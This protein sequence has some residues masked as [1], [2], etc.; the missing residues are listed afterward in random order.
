M[1]NKVNVQMDKKSTILICV[2]I[3]SLLFV[4]FFVSLTRFSDNVPNE[5]VI[6][7]E[8]SYVSDHI[9]D[10]SVENTSIPTPSVNKYDYYDSINY[11]KV[12]VSN[13]NVKNGSLVLVD[14][15]VGCS[16]SDDELVPIHSSRTGK[17][18][19]KD[20]SLRLK[21]EAIKNID[22]FIMSFY[23]KY[24]NN[25]LGIAEG[26]KTAVSGAETDLST[27]Y[28]VK[29]TTYKTSNTLSDEDFGY[30]KEQSF[31]YG[32]IQRF[33][34]GKKDSTGF[35]ENLSIYRYVGLVHSC[36]MNHYNLSLEEYIDKIKT[37]K[38]IE[39]KNNYES[40]SVYVVYYVPMDQSKD[41]THV[42]VPSDERYE[43]TV[44]GDGSNGFIVTVKIK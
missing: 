9:D 28:S 3:F 11:T 44:S 33:P 38:V 34:G 15:S 6:S 31:K 26:Y 12:P 39:Y 7:E 30:L 27:G 36:Y 29:L 22:L 14:G 2:L 24:K 4:S 13:S 40:D 16:V 23:S 35:D 32:I 19:L 5:H 21:K 42:N 41:T 25:G 1:E 18:D 37:E 17:Y 43:C 10:T 8:E 20:Y